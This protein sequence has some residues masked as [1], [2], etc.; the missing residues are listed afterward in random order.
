MNTF[1]RHLLR[2]WLSILGLVLVAA[3]GI[4][5]V[6]VAL[7]DFRDIREAGA[8]GLD[9]WKYFFVTMPSFLAVALP[10]VLLISLLY[11]LG[12][13]H[14]A[15]ELTAMRAAGVGFPRMMAPIWLVGLICCALSW[16]LNA[17]IVPWS[18]EQSRA[19]KE[20]FDFRKQ[21]QSL[22]VDRIGAIYSVGF[23]NPN[24]RR[25][26][27][28]NRSSQF[29]HTAYGVSVSELDPRRREVSR[30]LAS[31]AF[32]DEK[33]GGW[34]FR[35]GR[36]LSFNPETAI[37][38]NSVPFKELSKERYSEDPDLMLLIDRRPIDLS[39]TEL[40]RLVD[41]FSLE[42]NPKGIPYAVRFYGLV[43]DILGPLIVIGLAIPFAVTGVRVNPAVG[44]SK[45]IGLF[46]LYYILEN[47][48]ISL[49]TKNYLDPASAAWL[50]NLAM[51]GLG[52]WFFFRI[53]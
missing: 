11:A 9:L 33:S 26:W 48:A 4:L 46:L 44:V 2:E 51:A 35:N 52:M 32:R 18:V 40:G 13:L 39:F 3:C 24:A 6:Q 36:V 47:V 8:H 19:L 53:P 49:A 23:D 21:A 20:S 22:P 12:K 31:E 5:L 38:E 16:W 42:N 10:L 25:L 34:V 7:D 37:N 29:T 43:A 50:P 41:Y 45:S 14:R 28:F 15:N 1:D 30:I 27:F 17:S